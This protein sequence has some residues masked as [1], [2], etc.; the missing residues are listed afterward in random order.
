MSANEMLAQYPAIFRKG[1]EQ[2][3]DDAHLEENFR[4]LEERLQQ[5]LHL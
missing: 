4:L 5:N 1:A 3:V 2:E